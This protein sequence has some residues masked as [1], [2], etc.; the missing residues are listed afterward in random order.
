[1]EVRPPFRRRGLGTGLLRAV[2]AAAHAAGAQR[3]V[4][5]ATPDGRLLYE[6]QGFRMIGEGITYWLH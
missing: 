3:A 2:G 4:L 5:N 6:T 1:M